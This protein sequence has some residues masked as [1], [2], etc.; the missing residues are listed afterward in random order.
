M[1]NIEF[2]ADER[3]NWTVVSFELKDVI[4]PEDLLNLNPPK[5]DPTK[6]VLLNGRG[7][8]WL[9][10]YLTHYYHLTAFVATCDPRLGGAVVVESHTRDFRVGEIIKGV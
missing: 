10:C 5:V 7:P 9:Y 4:S 3:E 8:I 2:I 1:E 6:G